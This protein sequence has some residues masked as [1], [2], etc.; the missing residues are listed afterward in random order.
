VNGRSF[1][2]AA[3]GLDNAHYVLRLFV[4]G[5]T[6]RSTRA[7][8]AVRK[9]CER[10]LQGRFDL[11][12]VDVYQQPQLIQDEQILATPTLIKYEPAPLRRII[13]DMSDTNRL[14]FGLGLALEVSSERG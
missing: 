4:T 2:E 10:R 14:C 11:E 13:G 12:I 8:R 7:I 1:S 3:D 6:P 9:L 5:M